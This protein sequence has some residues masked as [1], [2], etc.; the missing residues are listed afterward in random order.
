MTELLPRH[1]YT[2]STDAPLGHYART[3]EAI[4]LAP[5]V[6]PLHRTVAGEIDYEHYLRLA[7]AERSKAI[8]DIARAIGR[9]VAALFKGAVFGRLRLTGP[10]HI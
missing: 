2:Q 10:R 8:A 1:R 5:S 4:G 7:R 6:P 3:P 9:G